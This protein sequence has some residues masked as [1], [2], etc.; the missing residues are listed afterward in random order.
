[1]AANVES[2]KTAPFGEVQ[3]IP[4]RSR[5]AAPEYE[6]LKLGLIPR[7]MEDKWFIYYDEPFLAFH[8][9]WTGQPVYRVKLREI[10]DGSVVEEAQC[11]T[12]VVAKSDAQYQAMLLDFIVSNLLLGQ[13]KPFPVP[14]KMPEKLPGAY[15]HAVVGR[16]YPQTVVATKPWWK[17]WH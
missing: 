9:S 8:R 1:M 10:D 15:Q 16:G 5:F 17:F 14:A 6:K 4:Y 12:D 2:W 7:E 13:R 11:S 3:E